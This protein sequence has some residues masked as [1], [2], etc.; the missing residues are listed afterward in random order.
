MFVLSFLV[1]FIFNNQ[2]ALFLPSLIFT[3]IEYVRQKKW[4]TKPAE[5]PSSEVKKK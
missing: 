3:G 4:K 1:L 5:A 2:V